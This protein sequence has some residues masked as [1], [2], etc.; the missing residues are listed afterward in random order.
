MENEAD[1]FTGPIV[2]SIRQMI[3]AIYDAGKKVTIHEEN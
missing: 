3:R 1:E 2:F